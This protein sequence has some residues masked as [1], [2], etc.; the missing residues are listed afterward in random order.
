M[1]LLLKHSS[2]NMQYNLRTH[3]KNFLAKYALKFTKLLLE[4][5]L[6][7]MLSNLQWKALFMQILQGRI[8]LV[9]LKNHSNRKVQLE[10]HVTAIHEGRKLFKCNICID[11]FGSKTSLSKEPFKC[12]FCNK[13]FSRKVTTYWLIRNSYYFMIWNLSLK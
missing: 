2:Q 7:N 12:N 1:K 9:S 11:S 3:F 10:R 8:H 6:Q 13:E 5:S 4:H